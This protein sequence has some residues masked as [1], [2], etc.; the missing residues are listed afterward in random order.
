MSGGGG[1][2]DD[3]RE[4]MRRDNTQ[5]A[6]SPDYSPVGSYSAP[7]AV[8]RR[9]SSRRRHEDEQLYSLHGRRM[10]SRS[11]SPRRPSRRA[12]PRSC[13]S[14]SRTRS[15]EC[16][17][18]RCCSPHSDDHRDEYDDGE[19]SWY[20][21]NPGE[22]EFTVRIDGIGANDG[23]FQC[24]ECFTMLSSPVYE[25]KNGDVM[26]G[27]CYEEGG[28]EEENQNGEEEEDEGCHQCGTKEIHHAVSRLLR[29]IRFACK[30]HRHG[31]CPAFLP[32]RDMDAHELACDHG[33]CFCPIRRCGFSGAADSLC[34][35]LTSRHGWGRLAVTYGAAA[36]VP[37][38]SPTILRATDDGRVFHLSCSRE[39]GWTVMAMV[40]IRPENGGGGAAGGEVE[41]EFRYEV[42][43]AC[44]RIQMQA[45]VEKTSLRLGM[46]EAVKARVTVPDEMLLYQGDAVEVCVRKEVA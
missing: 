45:A 8:H 41:E 6:H 34:R 2:E 19:G 18:S 33:P 4:A 23:I 11:R 39:R 15:Y 35:H 10:R 5:A 40:C 38:F 44:G 27:N 46:K 30:N 3:W 37:V 28:G 32:R 22:N 26:C 12:R 43:T 20:R 31:C 16:E 17:D 9:R 21:A 14:R 42:R 36:V 24:D 29:S 13:R 7:S 1:G 25:C